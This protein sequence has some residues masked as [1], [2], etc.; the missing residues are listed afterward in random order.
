MCDGYLRNDS[1]LMASPR[2]S[3]TQLL[4]DRLRT[5]QHKITADETYQASRKKDAT[6]MG[7]ESLISSRGPRLLRLVLQLLPRGHRG[8]LLPTTSPRRLMSTRPASTCL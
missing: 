2:Y 4:A 5:H 3:A 8:P 7:E 6:E 1:T